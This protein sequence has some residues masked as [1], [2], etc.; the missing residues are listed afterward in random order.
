MNSREKKLLGLVLI[1]FL[2]AVG[3]FLMSAL[4]EFQNESMVASKAA[5]ANAAVAQMSSRTAALPLSADGR[6]RLAAA[7]LP[8][9]SDPLEAVPASQRFARNGEQLPFISV[10]GFVHMG[11]TH[12]VILG[13]VEFAEGDVIPET[14]EV[15]VSIYNDA[16]QL[17]LPGTDTRRRL[18]YVERDVDT[19]AENSAGAKTESTK[20]VTARTAQ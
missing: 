10:D 6:R 18:T 8:L 15:V 1:V 7:S 9:E 4:N 16:V 11:R 17:E 13:G 14:G 2:V 12:L 5:E 19:D 3:D 20:A